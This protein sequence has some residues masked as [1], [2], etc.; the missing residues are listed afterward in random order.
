MDNIANMLIRMQNTHTIKLILIGLLLL[1]FWIYLPPFAN[2]WVG[3][4]YVQLGYVKE[5]VERPLTF[6]RIFHP[7]WTSWYY[8]PA[9]NVWILLGELLFGKRPFPFYAV[10]L[11]VHLLT[12]SL[13]FR[14][15]RQVQVGTFLAICAATLFTI[16]PHHVDVVT[17]ISAIGIVLAGLFSLTAL[18]TWLAY[19]DKPQS[20]TLL[21]T[22]LFCLLALLSHEESIILPPFLLLILIV[23][24]REKIR[25]QKKKQVQ[26]GVS[27]TLNSNEW[28]FAIG[29]AMLLSAYVVM[30]LLRPNATIN[31]SANAPQLL[32]TV[33]SPT[34]FAQFWLVTLHKFTFLSTFPTLTGIRMGIVVIGTVVLLAVWFWAARPAAR[35]GLLWTALH[36]LFIY[37][38]L[39]SQKPEL[40]AGRH[41]YVGGAGLVIA[42]G[43][44]LQQ[45]FDWWQENKVVQW[46]WV[47]V[48]MVVGGITAVSFNNYTLVQGI[49]SNWMANVTEEEAIIPTLR[50]IMP[51]INP[52]THVYAHRFPITP[53]FLR[54]FVYVWYGVMPTHPGGTLDMLLEHGEAA[55]GDYV[56]DYV[57]GEL[58]NLMPE[59]QAHQKTILLLAQEARLTVLPLHDEPIS[60]SKLPNVPIVTN[61]RLAQPMTPPDT[62]SW[63]SHQLITPIPGNSTLEFGILQ[64]AEL[65]YRVQ[66][67]NSANESFLLFDSQMVAQTTD[68]WLDISLPLQAYWEQPII[69][70]FEVMSKDI[71]SQP[72][73]YYAN[74][75]F[76]ID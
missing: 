37:L 22:S 35:W 68:G 30:Q 40:Y 61:L 1:I 15:L 51:D 74:P 32:Q 46:Q 11:G 4:D 73:G 43:T 48:M 76:T 67:T 69:L 62:E 18:T 58:Y 28:A 12:V 8:R 44:G 54:S 50:Q 9:Q 2:S 57:D 19:L 53:N 5:F 10:Q 24:R 13:V 27:H 75:R 3:D 31:L 64:H 66:L 14:I 72:T 33:F 55:Q 63:L 20:K 52:D 56:F 39:W 59:L 65:R 26:P 16:H 71:I 6:P 41:I 29:F 45:L 21:L 47:L 42:I 23:Q 17:W 60:L 36:L 25:S 34:T 70:S 49:Q 38:V 7:T